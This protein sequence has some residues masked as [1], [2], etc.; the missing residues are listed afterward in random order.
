ME[1]LQLKLSKSS[2]PGFP[3]EDGDTANEKVD[4]MLS[5]ETDVRAEFLA[6][7]AL[8]VGVEVFVEM[9]FELEGHFGHLLL[10]I[11]TGLGKLDGLEF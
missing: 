7:H 4:N 2:S 6:D 3:E 9:A 10:L 1:R 11:E 5:F 8:P